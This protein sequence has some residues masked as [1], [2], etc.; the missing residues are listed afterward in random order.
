M[1]RYLML[2]TALLLL[3]SVSLDKKPKPTIFII[4]DSTVKND[5]GKGEGSSHI[6]IT[7]HTHTNEAGAILN[8]N[9]VTEGI[10]L[11]KGCKLKR[12]IRP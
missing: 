9:A 6:F 3:T 8:A 10:K 11:L 12:F 7:D 4:C 1:I 2:S 5:S